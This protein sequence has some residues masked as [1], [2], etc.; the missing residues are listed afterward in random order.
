ML[1][2]KEV[3][4]RLDKINMNIVTC[5]ECWS[6]LFHDTKHKRKLK[7]KYCKHENDPCYFPDFIY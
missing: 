5:G 3:L 6:I 4:K 2:D 1:T 7:C